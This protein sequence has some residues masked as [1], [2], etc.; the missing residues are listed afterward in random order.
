MPP[1]IYSADIGDIKDYLEG[2]SDAP[3]SVPVK[4]PRAPR[5]PR[6]KKAIDENDN[7]LPDEP[8]VDDKEPSESE[9]KPKRTRVRKQPS[10]TP[11]VPKKP[12]VRRVRKT[13]T[14][15]S[16][17]GNDVGDDSEI[18]QEVPSS[19]KENIAGELG[20]GNKEPVKKTPR[21]PRKPRAKKIQPPAELSDDPIEETEDNDG[22]DI[23]ATSPAAT[24]TPKPKPKPK[25][26]RQSKVQFVIRDGEAVAKSD[27]TSLDESAEVESGGDD[28]AIKPKKQRTRKPPN[29]ERTAQLQ[30]RRLT[31]LFED[32]FEAKMKE[33]G[34]TVSSKDLR[35]AAELSA[36]EHINNSSITKEIETKKQAEQ[37]IALSMYKKIFS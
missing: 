13:P 17:N 21:A 10:A 19:D 36:S 25:R 16:P 14:K 5:K 18:D 33:D 9:P 12:P 7:A 32:M 8:I 3:P 6:T 2:K 23:N 34:T 37:A 35:Q 1:K 22:D 20:N 15:P 31:K 24:P 29:P 4:K 27:P 26:K 11:A 28:V 30:R